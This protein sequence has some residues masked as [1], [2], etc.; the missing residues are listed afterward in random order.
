MGGS[1][2]REYIWRK[3]KRL[4]KA[5]ERDW[6]RTRKA[7]KQKENEGHARQ[8]LINGLAGAL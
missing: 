1:R 5:Q 8:S 4:E 3:E 7:R 2:G 6:H